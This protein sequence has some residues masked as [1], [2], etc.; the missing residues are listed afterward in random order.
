MKRLLVAAAIAVAVVVAATRAP[1][2]EASAPE[3]ATAR[4][5]A[6]TGPNGKTVATF[7]AEAAS[8]DSPEVTAIQLPPSRFFPNAKVVARVREPAGANGVERVID[9]V[10]TKM[11]QPYVRVERILSPRKAGGQRVTREVAMVA[12]QLLLQKPESVSG[13]DFARMLARAGASEVKPIGDTYLATF[14]AEPRD[15]RALD[16]YVSRVREVAGADVTVEPN[17]I[18]KLF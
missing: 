14:A 10:E 8:V 17:Y 7:A 15:P 18:R 11:H 9:T 12:N 6:A 5:F 2:P 1:S 16:T 13:A 3:S 4:P